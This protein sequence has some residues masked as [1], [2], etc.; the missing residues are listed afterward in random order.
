MPFMCECTYTA[1]CARYVEKCASRVHSVC[2][3]T[4]GWAGVDCMVPSVLTT[5]STHNPMFCVLIA[6]T[7]FWLKLKAC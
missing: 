1:G 7:V 3:V 4:L 5:Q 6:L 2:L